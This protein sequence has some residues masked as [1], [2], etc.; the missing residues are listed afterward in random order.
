MSNKILRQ[1]G[2]LIAFGGLYFLGFKARAFQP[3]PIWSILS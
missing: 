3:L 2:T 1:Y